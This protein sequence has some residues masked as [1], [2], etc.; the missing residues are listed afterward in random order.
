[1]SITDKHLALV[2]LLMLVLHLL[3]PHLIFGQS[4]AGHK[5]GVKYQGYCGW[6]VYQGKL[7]PGDPEVYVIGGVGD[8]IYFADKRAKRKWNFAHKYYA[9]SPERRADGNWHAELKRGSAKKK[10][11]EAHRR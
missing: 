4:A 5:P 11:Y 7:I 1:M 10:K 2:V 3:F 8:T 9:H 6:A